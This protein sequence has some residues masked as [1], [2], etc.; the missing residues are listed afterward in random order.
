LPYIEKLHQRFKSQGLGVL[1]VCDNGDENETRQTWRDESFTMP[2][3][4][5]GTG[6][7]DLKQLFGI[8]NEPIIIVIDSKGTIVGVFDDYYSEAMRKTLE[9]IGF[10][11]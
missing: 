6:S 2:C 4:Q 9:R 1:A 7:S 11:Y 8:V 10:K 5:N 3:A